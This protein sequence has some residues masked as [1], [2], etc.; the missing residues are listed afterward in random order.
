MEFSVK[1][2]IVKSGFSIVYIEGLQI[3]TS[4][5]IAFLS[6]KTD[7]VLINSAGPDEILPYAQF[8][9]DVHCLPLYPLRGFWSLFWLI[10]SVHIQAF[11]QENKFFILFEIQCNIK[12]SILII[13]P[14]VKTNEP[15]HEISSNL[16]C[17]TSKA[18]TSLR[19]RAD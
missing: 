12:C 17:V 6:L 11:M 5:N 19:I 7:F 4:K 3:I 13:H 15:W 9:L 8:H 2:D 16:V 1:F 18:K 14:P 10:C